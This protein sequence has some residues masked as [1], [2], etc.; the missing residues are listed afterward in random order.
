[1]SIIKARLARILVRIF[2][3]AGNW[4][5]QPVTLRAYRPDWP[6]CCHDL[7]ELRRVLDDMR[8]ECGRQGM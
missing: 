6:E 8:R 2:A 7:D 1:M 4:W 3:T 5:H